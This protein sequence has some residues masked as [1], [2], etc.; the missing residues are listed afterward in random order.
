[1]YV[2]IYLYSNY[3]VGTVLKSTVW[4]ARGQFIEGVFYNAKAYNYL[5]TSNSL[6]CSD[7][8]FS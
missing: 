4:E 6:L 5:P 2:C 8:S 1:M 3:T 7:I